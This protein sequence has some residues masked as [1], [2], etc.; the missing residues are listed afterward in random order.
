MSTKKQVLGLVLNYEEIRLFDSIVLFYE[1]K[2][3]L[4]GSIIF[5]FTIILPVFKYVEI[6]NRIFVLIR[7]PAKLDRLLH[8]LDKWSMLDVFII[9]LL[10]LNFKMNSTILVMQIKVGTLFL[11]ISIIVR[12]VCTMVHEYLAQGASEIYGKPMHK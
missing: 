6:G 5:L 9:A 10:I 2:E 8:L 12:M 11:A 7:L 1:G 4:L 3:Y